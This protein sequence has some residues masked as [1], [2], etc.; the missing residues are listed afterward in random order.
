MFSSSIYRLPKDLVAKALVCVC[1][2]EER[3]YR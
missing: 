2:G 1:A 3:R